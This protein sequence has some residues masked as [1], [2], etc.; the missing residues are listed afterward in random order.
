MV[1]ILVFSVLIVHE[2]PPILCES[3]GHRIKNFNSKKNNSPNLKPLMV[4][5]KLVVFDGVH[6]SIFTKIGSSL[7]LNYQPSFTF[8]KTIEKSSITSIF[9]TENMEGLGLEWTTDG[10]VKFE[11]FAVPQSDSEVIMIVDYLKSNTSVL[12]RENASYINCWN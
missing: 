11:F 12:S 8:S 1:R 7:S 5:E 3:D 4:G 9:V 10:N 6:S 2:N